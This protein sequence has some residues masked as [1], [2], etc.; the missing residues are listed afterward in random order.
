MVSSLLLLLL[1]S[2]AP[3]GAHGHSG[4]MESAVTAGLVADVAD[5]ERFCRF[6]LRTSGP[7]VAAF[8]AVACDLWRAGPG[9]TPGSDAAAR[10]AELDGEFGARVASPASRAA[11]RQLGSGLRRLVR[12]MAPGADLATPWRLVPGPAPHQ[13]LVLGAAV[14]VAEG[15]AR[16]AA[17]AAALGT[18]TVP[19]SAAVRLLG[20]DPYAVQGVLAWPPRSTRRAGPA[21]N[22][23][24]GAAGSRT[25]AACR[26]PGAGPLREIARGSRA[27]AGA[28]R[29]RPRPLGGA[30]VCILTMTLGL[31]VTSTITPGP[32]FTTMSTAPPESR[33]A[34]PPGKCR[35]SAS[36]ARSE[37]ARR[38]WSPRFAGR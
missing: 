18:C 30:S 13:P 24:R 26:S 4:G 7:A 36:A 25:G 2:R 28:A 23:P 21:R 29:R 12:S 6:R 15:D 11:S 3:A 14:A 1:D 22:S 20:L 37:A 34:R 5:V 31:P 38:H 35:G 10:W 8:A 32:T 33:P 27:C 16:L 9:D 19:A 17:L